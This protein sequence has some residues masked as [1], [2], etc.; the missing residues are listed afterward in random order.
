MIQDDPVTTRPGTEYIVS[1]IRD[2]RRC[3]A[4]LQEA[5]DNCGSLRFKSRFRR[6]FLGTVLSTSSSRDLRFNSLSISVSSFGLTPMCRV[7][8]SSR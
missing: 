3:C 2:F 1:P 6:M 4:V 5:C 7:E 8:K